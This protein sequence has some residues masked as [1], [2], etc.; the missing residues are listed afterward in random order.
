MQG[1]QPSTKV[2]CKP[3]LESYKVLIGVDGLPAPSRMLNPLSSCPLPTD[4]PQGLNK[5]TR[6]HHSDYVHARALSRLLM[7][8]ADLEGRDMKGKIKRRD[9]CYE[10]KVLK[11]H[12]VKPP[13]PAR[14]S[15]PPPPTHD[16]VS[17]DTAESPYCCNTSVD[18]AY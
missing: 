16:F 9:C 1:I 17:Q 3:S 2:H 14:Q 10:G 8:Q 6:R 13:T 15:V 11:D 7:V 5:M 18:K 12:E 4:I